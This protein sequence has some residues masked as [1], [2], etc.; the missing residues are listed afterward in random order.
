M[1]EKGLTAGV[2]PAT[3]GAAAGS[4]TALADVDTEREAAGPTWPTLDG[5]VEEGVACGCGCWEP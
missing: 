5:A 2:M 3:L 4:P 1:G